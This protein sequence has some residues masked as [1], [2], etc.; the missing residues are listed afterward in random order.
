[1]KSYRAGFSV[2][3]VL[4]I[5]V[6]VI[7]VSGMGW[8]M[9]THIEASKNSTTTGGTSDSNQ[10]SCSINGVPEQLCARAKQAGYYCPSWDTKPGQV[11]PEICFKVQ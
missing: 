3:E 11:A 5:L 7:A 1:M 9:Y 6:V 8:I 4:L 2:I 10:T